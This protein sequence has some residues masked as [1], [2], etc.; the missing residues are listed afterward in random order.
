MIITIL[1]AGHGG[2]A[3]AADLTLAGHEVRLAAVPEHATNI[4]LLNAF[5]CI[6]LEGKTSSGVPPGR[7]NPAMIT[8]DVAAAIK[9]SQVIMIV[10]PAFGQEPYMHAL[11]EHG[12]KGQIIVFNPG[13][14]GALAFAKMLSD[15]G[16]SNDFIIGE[17]S[18]LIFAAKTKGLGHVNIKA[19]KA[20]LPFAAL[21][22]VK[23]GEALWTLMDIYPQFMPATN[24][25]STSVD[26]PGAIVHPISTLLNMSRIEQM[27]PYRNSHY[28]IT[29]GIANIIQ[30]ID[31]ERLDIARILCYETYSLHE[32][33]QIMYKVKLGTLYESIY[34][35]SAH[36]VQM[37]PDNLNHR[38]ITEDIPYGLV[39]LGSLGRLL[40]IPTPGIDA[41]INIASMANKVNYREIGRTT[42]KLGIHNFRL[43]Q[44]IDY[45]T[46]INGN[47]NKK[48][49]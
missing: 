47:L 3:M 15:L 38:Y 37:A 13:K 30:A 28:D 10:V 42:E 25:L 5:G 11:L 33:I 12:E 35:I 16:R 22:S 41:I 17:T 27:G 49:L 43:H 20:E 7:A 14:F 24:V 29:P 36:N 18:C 19:V 46:G 26:D 6:I 48:S 4:R 23:T 44:L 31:N 9:G 39:T 1:G 2:Q 40:N 21:P 45:V 32:S 34:Q 8:T